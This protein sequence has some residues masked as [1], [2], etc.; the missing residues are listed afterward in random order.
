MLSA[1][2]TA[3]GLL[4]LA[5]PVILCALLASAPARANGRFPRADQLVLAPGNADELWLR[6]TFGL[7]VSRDAGASWDWVCERAIGFSGSE[8]PPLQ[9]LPNGVVLAGLLE[10]LVQ[11]GDRG[12]SWQFAAIPEQ[13]LPIID[14]SARREPPSLAM[15]LAWEQQA[16]STSAPGYRARFFASADGGAHWQA[17]GVGIDPGVLVL[18]LDV[19]PSDAQR[20]YAS[21]IRNGA[22]RSAALFVSNDAGTSWTEH[23][24]PF[25]ARSEQGLYI[26]AVDPFSPDL[27]YLRTSGASASRLLVST[28]AGAS[29]VER[30][31]GEPLLGFALSPDG[32]QIY[33]G[34]VV[35]G[36]SVAAR[37][38]FLFEQRSALP[39]VCL[40]ATADT[41]Y[42]CSNERGG[43]ALGASRDAGTSFQPLLVLSDVRGPLACPSGASVGLCAADWPA[44][45]D[46]LGIEACTA[47]GAADSPAEPRTSRSAANGARGCAVGTPAR[48]GPLHSG[49]TIALV[50]GVAGVLRRRRSARAASMPG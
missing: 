42:A 5:P 38:D 50:L 27:L 4:G 8:D 37:G 28:D 20:L 39:I 14:L 6:T 24:V 1:Q 47:A 21:G 13:Q 15:A 23:V 45:S 3:R 44:L 10:G 31:T 30:Y 33:M 2:R 43:F 11:S 41:L 29:F 7:L 22:E 16:A 9:V 48:G 32:A 19:A 18:T 34:G 12:C 46:R 49:W 25:D 40:A 26:A 36:L 35:G 17:R